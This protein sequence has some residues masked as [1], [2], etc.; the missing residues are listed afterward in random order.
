MMP[1]KVVLKT[2]QTSELIASITI[3]NRLQ[4]GN[5]IT[6]NGMRDPHFFLKTQ[7][8]LP[9]LIFAGTVKLL[10]GSSI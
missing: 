2:I 10:Y 5:P 4:N 3:P 7:L 1:V 8:G 9:I 6:I